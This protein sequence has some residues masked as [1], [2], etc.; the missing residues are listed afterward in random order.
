MKKKSE[1]PQYVNGH[2]DV[3]SPTRFPKTA[4]TPRS[5][6]QTFIFSVFTLN[7]AEQREEA[8]VEDVYLSF[9]IF[10]IF[11]GMPLFLLKQ[12]SQCERLQAHIKRDLILWKSDFRNQSLIIKEMMQ[13]QKARFPW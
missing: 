4:V 1:A 13:A 12:Y 8:H 6:A 11:P 7:R 5:D 3:W 10:Q 9:V 2:F